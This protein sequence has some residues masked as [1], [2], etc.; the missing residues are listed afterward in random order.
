MI[1]LIISN[2]SIDS[3]LV[4]SGNWESTDF[5]NEY[6]ISIN[7]QVPNSFSII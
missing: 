2:A 4:V 5:L 7:E 6:K 1:F 3:S